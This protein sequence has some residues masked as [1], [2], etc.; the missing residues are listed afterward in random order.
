MSYVL[1]TQGSLP[2]VL[3]S[4]VVDVNGTGLPDALLVPSQAKFLSGLPGR[5][6]A[7]GGG[8]DTLL[9]TF[10]P[11]GLGDSAWQNVTGWEYVLLIGGGYQNLTLGAFAQ[12]AFTSGV[13]T[14]MGASTNGM[15]VDG[16]ALTVGSSLKAVGGAGTDVIRGGAGA[17][18][19]WATVGNDNIYGGGGDDIFEVGTVGL[20]LSTYIEGGAGIDR[21]NLSG[22]GAITDV[23]FGNKQTIEQ[24]VLNAGAWTLTLGNAAASAFGGVVNI[25]GA[26]VAT[27]LTIDASGM[28]NGQLLAAGGAGADIIIGGSG[29]DTITGGGGADSLTGGL[30][31]DLFKFQ[32]TPQLAGSIVSGGD[33]FDQ[34]EIMGDNLGANSFI[35][36]AGAELEQVVLTA[37]APLYA[38][39]TDADAAAFTGGL[40]RLAASGTGVT[41]FT[42][43]G[44]FLTGTNA[45]YVFGVTTSNEVTGGAGA[46]TFK[47]GVGVGTSNL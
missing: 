30:G 34:V 7:G 16:S 23:A 46:D 19:I 33:G 39:V 42:A 17:D 22:G 10:N 21:I 4:N 2:Q 9:F 32:V 13:I 8:A 14:L 36:S 11:N 41:P 15:N 5:T 18:Q 27:G 43:Y 28:S 37:N 24:V 29:N 26:G 1:T 25:A 12:A 38:I 20:L 3:A 47:A 6:L 45:V 40:I 31:D 35:L 44:G